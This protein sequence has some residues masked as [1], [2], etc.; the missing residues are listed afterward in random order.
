RLDA[1]LVTDGARVLDLATNF[2]LVGVAQAA[3]V[4]V[5]HVIG[6]R[7]KAMAVGF[8]QARDG[9]QC[10]KGLALTAGGQQANRFAT[11]AGQLGRKRHGSSSY[12]R[13]AGGRGMM[14]ARVQR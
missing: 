8:Q 14:R 6:E 13:P 5:L 9:T 4:C 12:A 3:A 2:L 10:S 1:F 7:M 11:L